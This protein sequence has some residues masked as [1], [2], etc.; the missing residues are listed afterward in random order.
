MFQFF[1]F[2]SLIALIISDCVPNGEL[3][4]AKMEEKRKDP[5]KPP[6]NGL[7]L[8]LKFQRFQLN[9]ENSHLIIDGFLTKRYVDKD[10]DY[11]NENPCEEYAI[12]RITN[13]SAFK[14]PKVS[15]MAGEWINSNDRTEANAIVYPNG[16]VFETQR[17]A[18]SAPCISNSS[19]AFSKLSCRLIWHNL[20]YRQTEMFIVW[21]DDIKNNPSALVH[22]E[23][24]TASDYNIENFN[25]EHHVVRKIIGD[26][27]ELTFEAIL[28][29]SKFKEFVTFYLP[30]LMFVSISWLSMFLG[31]MAITRSVL[32]IGSMILL[33]IPRHLISPST[34]IAASSFTNCDIWQL[35]TL[36]FTFATLVELIFIT[37]MASAGRSGR[38]LSCFGKKSDK[39]AGRN[40]YSFEPLY[41]ELNDL[42]TRKARKTCACCSYSALVLDILSIIAFAVIFSFFCLLYFFSNEKI[43]AA[44][45]NFSSFSSS[46]ES[47]T[48]SPEAEGRF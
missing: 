5:H 31:P 22:Q 43:V 3:L 25:F 38:L 16:T 24:S 15:L 14:T 45:N 13:T 2:A 7:Q 17:V 12:V 9:S 48:F 33:T 29:K 37:C 21:A 23:I 41:E 35:T 32:I 6:T 42:R 8:S 44:F 27:D 18:L 10:Y 1:I 26:F 30:Q 20:D 40:Y 39:K 4:K 11:S 36:F 46:E 19:T 47:S 34:F 28:Q